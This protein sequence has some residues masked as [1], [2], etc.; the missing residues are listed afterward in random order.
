[1]ASKYLNIKDNKKRQIVLKKESNSLAR[2][3]TN[4]ISGRINY[5]NQPL[6]LN[7][8]LL[9]NS[10][11][12]DNNTKNLLSIKKFNSKIIKSKKFQG[13]IKNL[14]KLEYNNNILIK[15]FNI[16][17]KLIKNS[18]FIRVKNR[19]IISG[20]SH[21]IHRLFKLSRIKLRELGSHG[22]LMGLM[23]AS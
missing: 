16:N 12:Y 23:K 4:I 2:K 15:Y 8:I 3:T 21:A 17:K 1:M 10:L 5:F 18:S 22:K 19:C 7:N 6:I 14:Y 9:K 11:F 20:R 13:I